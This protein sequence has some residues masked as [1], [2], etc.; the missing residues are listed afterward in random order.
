MGDEIDLILLFWQG[1]LFSNRAKTMVANQ[2]KNR[3]IVN[4][5]VLDAMSL[6]KRHLFVSKI[7]QV[8]GLY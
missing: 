1:V 4:T 5:D 2:F 6:V 8:Y 3:G 7:I